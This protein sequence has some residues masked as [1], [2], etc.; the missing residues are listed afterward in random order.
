MNPNPAKPAKPTKLAEPA[1]PAKPP[2]PAKPDNPG[3]PAGTGLGQKSFGKPP[4]SLQGGFSETFGPKTF[5]SQ[6]VWDGI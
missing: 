4:E 3:E 6:N 5:P 1:K 2:R